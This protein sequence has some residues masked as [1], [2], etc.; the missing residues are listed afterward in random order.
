MFVAV[1]RVRIDAAKEAQYITAWRR[2]TEA[3][4]KEGGSFGSA[5]VRTGAAQFIAIA[6]WPNETARHQFFAEAKGIEEEL[7]IMR[8]AVMERQPSLEGEVVLNLWT[9]P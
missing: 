8:D 4:Q 5:L 7:S 3:A 6:R 1:Y 2:V 9:V